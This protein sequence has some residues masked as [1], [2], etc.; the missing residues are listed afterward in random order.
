MKIQELNL[1]LAE[2]ELLEEGLDTFDKLMDYLEE[3]GSFELIKGIGPV[4]NKEILSAIEKTLSEKTPITIQIPLPANDE[5]KQ[6][7]VGVEDTESPPGEPSVPASVAVEPTID[8]TPV[9][10]TAPQNASVSPKT[11]PSTLTDV[12]CVTLIH[13]RGH[14]SQ[15]SKMRKGEVANFWN[16]NKQNWRSYEVCVCNC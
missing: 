8:K 10:P 3:H 12:V 5:D 15:C 9:K 11:I 7:E 6:E 14:R 13:A 1:T 4:T 16:L 2:P